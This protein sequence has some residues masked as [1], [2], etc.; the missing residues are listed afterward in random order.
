V[1]LQ[2]QR[3]ALDGC[4]VGTFS[5]LNKTLFE[6]FLS[7]S[8]LGNAPAVGAFAAEIVG[9]ALAICRLRE[10]AGEREFANAARA[11]KEQSVGHAL[12]AQSTAESRDDA[13]VAEKFLK[14]QG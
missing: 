6:E 11:G 12:G 7:I 5:A 8:E 14:A 9:H 2:N 13:F 3:N 1:G 4:G 10:H